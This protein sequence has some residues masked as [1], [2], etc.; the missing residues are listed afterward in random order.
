MGTGVKMEDAQVHKEIGLIKKRNAKVEADKA[1]ETSL[2]RKGIICTF[3]YFVVVL[4][5][6]I[7]GAEQPWLAG[8]VPAIAYFLSTL[9]LPFAKKWWLKKRVKK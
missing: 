9:T 2:V 8:L 7:S 6:C 4:V 1:W 3:T 5:L